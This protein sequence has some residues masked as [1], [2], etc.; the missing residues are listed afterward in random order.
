[1]I[2]QADLHAHLLMSSLGSLAVMPMLQVV[3]V[4]YRA[5]EI[6]LGEHLA[7]LLALSR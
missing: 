5:P 2:G 3:T 1:M 6:L 7:S 4:W